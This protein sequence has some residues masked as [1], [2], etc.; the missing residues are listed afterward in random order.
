[1]LSDSDAQHLH[2]PARNK[3]QRYSPAIRLPCV[4]S[5]DNP[6]FQRTNIFFILLT[7]L[8]WSQ[9]CTEQWVMGI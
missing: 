1:M 5:S 6:T 8:L 7:A 2:L 3:S 9:L 4:A